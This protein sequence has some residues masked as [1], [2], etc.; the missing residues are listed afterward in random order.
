MSIPSL[1]PETQTRAD[2]ISPDQVAESDRP[3][4]W[5]WIVEPGSLTG[6]LETHLRATVEVERI[7]EGQNSE[8]DLRREVRLYAA[9]RPL[10]YA[11]S[12]I[13]AEL[14]EQLE[15]VSA[16]GDQPLGARL[17]AAPGAVREDLKVA[18]L[19]EDDPL[20]H[21]ACAGLD[22]R[23]TSLWARRSRLVVEKRS[24]LIIECFLQGASG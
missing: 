3:R 15:W 4:N 11:V 7:S 19:S 18:L 6:L 14:L 17:F 10:I 24:M 20:V 16:L 9:G 23:P 21:Q 13:P 12:H 2:W 8:G 1:Q 5:A 22:R